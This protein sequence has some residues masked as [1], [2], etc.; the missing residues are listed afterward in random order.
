LTIH[1]FIGYLGQI[2]N[3]KEEFVLP[4]RLEKHWETMKPEILVRWDKLSPYDLVYVE[5]RF[6]RLVELI[7]HRYMP[8]RS[9]LSIE[10]EVRDW[11]VKKITELER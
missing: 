1:L 4:N 9:P 10:A 3:E 6:D 2:G 7:R 5:G 8:S 11:L